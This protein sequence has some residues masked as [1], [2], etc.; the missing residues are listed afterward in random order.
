MKRESLDPGVRGWGCPHTNQLTERISSVAKR[1]VR[2]RIE[3]ETLVDELDEERSL[4]EMDE[5]LRDMMVRHVD[6]RTQ[7][8]EVE[9]LSSE[10]VDWGTK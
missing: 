5:S 3:G 8:Y 4:D 2:W 10:L 1:L 9:M 7:K 6:I